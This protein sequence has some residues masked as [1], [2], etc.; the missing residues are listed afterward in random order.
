MHSVVSLL[1]LTVASCSTTKQMSQDPVG[2]LPYVERQVAIVNQSQ[3]V[4]L[5]GT[6]TLPFDGSDVPAVILIT[7]SG[8]Q[9]RNE[10]TVGATSDHKPFLI[11]SDYFTR[12]GLAVLRMDDRGVGG[13]S[14]D[15][16]GSTIVDFS[17]DIVA[18]V[19]FLKEQRQIDPQK[20][21][22]LGHSEG[23][24][25]AAMTAAGNPEV[26]FVVLMAGVGLPASELVPLQTIRSLEAE[27]YSEEKIRQYVQV[28][29]D[30]TQIISQTATVDRIKEDLH[31]YLKLQGYRENQIPAII[32][33]L[34]APNKLLLVHHNPED[35]LQAISCPVLAI[36]GSL[37]V[38]APSK[39]NLAAIES[40][41]LK[42]GNKKVTIVELDEHN[43][44]LQRANTGAIS[45]YGK[46]A[47]TVSEVALSTMTDWI[48]AQTR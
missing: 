28:Q 27:G 46:I 35:S 34:V 12:H 25:V 39:E 4:Q 29:L 40:A 41:L 30:I 48:L 33:R 23:S 1:L 6:L 32:E 19:S 3:G 14:G 21:G 36:S 38:Q 11:I 43:H 17:S 2:P 37:D 42:G 22:L 44:L 15:F 26:S 20:I 5:A 47:E 24:L 9:D 10:V 45:N 13:S 16:Y 7:G 8:R 31:E 18:A